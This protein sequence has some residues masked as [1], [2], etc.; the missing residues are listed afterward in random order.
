VDISVEGKRGERDLSIVFDGSA[1]AHVTGTK[2]DEFDVDMVC[3]PA[4]KR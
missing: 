4:A 3:E 2:G 1:T